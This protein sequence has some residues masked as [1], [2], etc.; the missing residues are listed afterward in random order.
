MI[1]E[2]VVVGYGVQRKRDVSTSI[3]SV[4]AEQIADVSASDFRQALAGK[5]PG[6]QVTQPSGDPEGSVS[7]RVRGIS[8]VN[9]GSDPL[10][11]ID[12]VP[13]KAG[14]HELNGND[15]ESI[16]VLKD[17]ASC[18]LYG[19]RASNGVILITTKKAKKQ[20]VSLQLDIRH[21]FSARGQGDYERMN[22]NQFMETMWQGYRN[23][24][25][26]NGSS[27][28]EATIATNND[29]ISKVGINIYNKADNALFVRKRSSGIRRPDYWT[30]IR[31]IST[32]ILLHT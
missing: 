12:G 10:Y 17:A 6:V 11:I 25:I 27:P 8:T 24:L 14:M 19:S 1:D 21:G 2:V 29:I 9:A 16:Q 5:M 18:A 23:Q 26:S 13:T 20:G 32:G 28:E 22:A 31:T 7:I 3:S 15:I 4:K 30:D